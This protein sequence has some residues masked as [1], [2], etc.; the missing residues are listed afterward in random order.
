MPSCALCVIRH[1]LPMNAEK[2]KILFSLKSKLMFLFGSLLLATIIL[3]SSINNY[4]L[5]K[6]LAQDVRYQQMPVFLEVGLGNFQEVLDVAIETATLL[7]DDVLLH[8]FFKN[9]QEN[10]SFRSVLLKQMENI[11]TFNY[12]LVF[13]GIKTTGEY[14]IR[15]NRKESYVLKRENPRDA[16]FF[17][18]LQSKEKINLNYELDTE[19][20]KNLLFLNVLVQDGGQ[21]IGVV[22]MGL[23]ITPAMQKFHQLLPIKGS[24]SS[25]LNPQ[26]EVVFSTAEET[27]GKSLKDLFNSQALTN[28]MAVQ[29]I[30]LFTNINHQNTDYD[31]AV[32]PMVKDFKVISYYPQKSLKLLSRFINKTK[33]TALFLFFSF[34]LLILF[35]LVH[36]FTLPLQSLQKSLSEFT[37]GN[38]DITVGANILERDDEVGNLAK[39]FAS[40]KDIANRISKMLVQAGN[41]SEVVRQ[42]SQK[43]KDASFVLAEASQR[44]IDSTHNLLHSVEQ[45]TST[46]LE[47]TG[48]VINTKNIFSKARDFAQDGE[49]TLQEV[50]AAIQQ[51]F[52]KIQ[53]VQSIS[54]QTNILSLNASIEALRAGDEGKGFA[55]VATEVQKL[56]ELTREAAVSINDLSIKTVEVTHNTGKIFN[57]LVLNTKETLSLIEE[58]SFKSGEQNAMAF[59]V[60]EGIEIIE[61]ISQKNSATAKSIDQLIDKFQNQIND[62]DR[63]M[64]DL[65]A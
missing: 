51:I 43:L 63:V 7:S 42:G 62:L 19:G 17:Q 49:D 36:N 60:N 32:L 40:T 5:N 13:A 65:R 25:L 26:G 27:I 48:H 6:N 4:V 52:I 56:A 45:M 47:S 15:G 8:K 37:K 14:Y 9:P 20:Q 1:L 21:T 35:F 33:Y 34:S 30:K 39:A 16:W 12:D 31:V 57:I 23:D 3:Y 18:T 54:V 28:I 11:G 55:V 44:Q 61:K 29:N 2:F 38:F 22:G 59:Q 58:I 53:T 41:V 24:V 10:F 64:T 46:V 50:I